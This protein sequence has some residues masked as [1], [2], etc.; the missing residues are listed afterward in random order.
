MH[1]NN[2]EWANTKSLNKRDKPYSIS[3]KTFYLNKN[4]R[5]AHW[6]R[7]SKLIELYINDFFK[8]KHTNEEMEAELTQ[9]D[10]KTD[11]LAVTEEANIDKV[12]PIDL[13]KE[14]S[15]LAYKETSGMDIENIAIFKIRNKVNRVKWM[16]IFEGIDEAYLRGSKSFSDNFMKECKDNSNEAQFIPLEINN[17]MKQMGM[18]Q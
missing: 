15:I 6:V 7:N 5:T 17:N 9:M 1:R 18:E 2:L 16:P 4:D 11:H 3:S 10:S 12:I 13:R 14:R 8:R